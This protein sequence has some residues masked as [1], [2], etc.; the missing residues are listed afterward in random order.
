M[1]TGLIEEMGT[2]TALR[3]LADAVELCVQCRDTV[4][5]TRLGDSIAVDGICLTVTACTADSFT[6]LASAETLRRT[7]LVFKQVGDRVNLERPLT[8]DKQLGGHMVQGHVDGAGRVLSIKQEGE[9]QMWTFG[10][11]PEL[12]KFFVS[13]GSVAVD[14]ISLTV[15]DVGRD[16]FT[17][18]IIPKTLAMTTFQFRKVGDIVNIETDIIGKYIYRFLHPDEPMQYVPPPPVADID[19]FARKGNN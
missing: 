10:I 17:V 14:G 7:N 11:A 2:L 18:S 1:F 5:G 4:K 12:A 8:L 13:K 9:C 15:V 19:L 3:P 6:T 16:F